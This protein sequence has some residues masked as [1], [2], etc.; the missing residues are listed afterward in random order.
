MVEWLKSLPQWFQMIVISS[1]TLFVF[2]L[3]LQAIKKGIKFK[4]GELSIGNKL[5]KK[6]KKHPHQDCVHAKDALVIIQKTIELVVERVDVK[7]YNSLKR[8]MNYAN[9]RGKQII[10]I[11]QKNYLNLLET[12]GIKDVVESDS[13]QVYRLVLLVL[14]DLMMDSIRN[15]FTNE[16]FNT[17]TELQFSSFLE[18]TIEMLL[19]EASEHL[20][21]LYFYNKI[22]T[23]EELYK[24]NMK[25]VLE[26]KNILKE[27]VVKAKIIEVENAGK[28]KEIDEDLIKLME[29]FGK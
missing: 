21:E 5:N 19:S 28:I 22:I 12:K 14:K 18:N 7:N 24:H 6:N 11:L 26:C 10:S 25:I 13:F 20:N 3:L 4:K 9:D 2:F 23:R 1:G 27:V 16:D 15:H 29:E 17:L 8:Q